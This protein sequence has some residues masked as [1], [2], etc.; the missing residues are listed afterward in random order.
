MVIRCAGQQCDQR[1]SRW[2]S[3]A[4]SSNVISGS[5]EHFNG[6]LDELRAIWI[7]KNA[8]YTGDNPDPFYNYSTSAALAGISTQQSLFGRLCEKVIRVSSLI[9]T[10]R[11]DNP[12]VTDESIIATLNDIAIQAIMLRE[13]IEG[14]TS[15]PDPVAE[16]NTLERTF[17]TD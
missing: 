9:K 8:D 7:A 14:R 10:G 11:T 4:R 6:I 13:E 12:K 3:A 16:M 15:P 2:L 1:Q 17:R 5:L